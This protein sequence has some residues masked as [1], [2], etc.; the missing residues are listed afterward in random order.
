MHNPLFITLKAKNNMTI[1]FKHTEF[2]A[3]YKIVAEASL[4]D[5]N[6]MKPMQKLLLYIMKDLHVKFYQK[7]INVKPIMSIKFS[8]KEA[9][10]WWLLFNQQTYPKGS[11]EE[12]VV[13]R[14]NA[15]IHQQII[16]T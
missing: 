4:L 2:T 7:A 5:D 15:L 1:R 16:I 3:I 14:L 6:G 12:F 11:F 13:D 10:A 8:P 9:V